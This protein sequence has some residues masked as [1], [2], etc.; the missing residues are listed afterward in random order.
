MID[1]LGYI[2][3]LYDINHDGYLTLKEVEEGYKALFNMLGRRNYDI[4]C[5]EMA[6]ATIADLG[7]TTGSHR[8]QIKRGIFSH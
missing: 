4:V 1:K 7:K 8:Y 3:D 6:E 5:K 2:F